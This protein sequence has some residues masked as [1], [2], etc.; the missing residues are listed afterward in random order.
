[1]K[2]RRGQEMG[3][4]KKLNSA[5]ITG[6]IVVSAILGVLSG[7]GTVFVVAAVILLALSWYSGEIR[8]GKRGW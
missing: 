8:P 7:S 6:T 1:M 4:R 3:A 5:A 2:V